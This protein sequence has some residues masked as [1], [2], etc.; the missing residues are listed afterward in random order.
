MADDSRIGLGKPRSNVEN[1]VQVVSSI[2]PHDS[3]YQKQT[4]WQDDT[5][6]VD[7]QLA[8]HPPANEKTKGKERKRYS[9]E[10]PDESLEYSLIPVTT[11]Y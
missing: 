3:V 2:L 6:I 4:V 1:H 9:R 7:E 11:F 10:G 5:N 8:K